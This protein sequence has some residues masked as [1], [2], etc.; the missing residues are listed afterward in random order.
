MSEPTVITGMLTTIAQEW[1][2]SAGLSSNLILKIHTGEIFHLEKVY[3]ILNGLGLLG[4][5]LTGVSMT[6]LFNKRRKAAGS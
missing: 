1:L 4:L 6:S 2:P 5:L 3:P